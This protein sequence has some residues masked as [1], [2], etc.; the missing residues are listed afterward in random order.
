MNLKDMTKQQLQ[1]YFL[2]VNSRF[3]EHL[4]GDIIKR[5]EQSFIETREKIHA[6]M[7]ELRRRREGD[8]SGK[9]AD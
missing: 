2:R 7:E 6:V 5:D 8:E 4:E 9:S 1:D 3:I